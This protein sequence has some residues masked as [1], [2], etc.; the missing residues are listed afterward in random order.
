MLHPHAHG[1]CGMRAAPGHGRTGFGRRA[2][3]MDWQALLQHLPVALSAAAPHEPGRQHQRY[4]L[5]A[6]HFAGA[7]GGRRGRMLISLYRDA[8]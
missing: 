8:V 4:A 5:V 1:Y 7:V 6:V 2:A 3:C